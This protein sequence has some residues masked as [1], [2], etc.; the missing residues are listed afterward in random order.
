MNYCLCGCGEEVSLGKKF[1][2]GHNRR[3]RKCSGETK[4]KM[5]IAKIG[6][7][8]SEETKIKISA[9]NTGKIHSEE[10]KA[11]MSIVGKG[12]KHSEEA[13]AKMS[14]AQTGKVLSE[15]H[16]AKISIASLGRKHSE[17]TK[18]KI[19]IGNS[20]GNN[21]NFGKNHSGKNSPNFGKIGKYHHSEEAKAKISASHSGEKCHLWQGGITNEPYG[22][23]NDEQV[24]EKI[25]IRDN[26]TCQKCGEL[27]I[28]G[29][30]KF[31]A[32]HIDYDKKHHVPW[33]RITLCRSCHS[34]TNLNRDYWMR[35]FYEINFNNC[36]QRILEWPGGLSK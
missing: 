36:V 27:W 16:K 7:H 10:A 18:R 34:K 32:H 8:C 26:F 30:E 29:K 23:G 14:A 4:V 21:Y 15:E 17:E 33:N 19:S 3:G 2:R 28:E 12:R 11:K 35:H 31:I 22:P 25:R 9:A 6:K 1:V 24:K 5:S 20:G 13:K